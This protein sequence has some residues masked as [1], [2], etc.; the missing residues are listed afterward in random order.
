MYN[1]EHGGFRKGLG[2]FK[3]SDAWRGAFKPMY[4]AFRN[5]REAKEYVDLIL[6]KPELAPTFNRL[7][8]NLNE[9]QMLT[10]RGQ[11]TTRAGK[12]V[13]NVLSVGEDFVGDL[14][15]FNRLQEFTIR[16]GV[17][18][19]QLE[20]LTKREW[21]IDLIEALNEG[22][23]TGMLNGS[24]KPEGKRSFYELIEDSTH[25]ATDITYAKQ[26]DTKLGR[27]FAHW[28]TNAS[29]GPARATWVLP[30]PRFMANAL[31]LM[32][33]YGAGASIPLTKKVISL[34]KGVSP[35]LSLMVFPVWIMGR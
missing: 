21:G 28:V 23:L 22:K 30:F 32:G 17:F 31:E 7:F 34:M 19:G 2:T 24:L 26:P 16:R 29:F 6:N 12:V 27:E 33:Q 35:L 5:P 10:G 15:V 20:N 13:D 18:F 4:H 14:N 1:L 11:A 3:S 8:G 9:I 25:L